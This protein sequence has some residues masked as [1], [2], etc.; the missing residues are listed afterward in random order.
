MLPLQ[1]RHILSK[2]SNQLSFSPM[3]FDSLSQ[4]IGLKNIAGEERKL[5]S[6]FRGSSFWLQK[7]SPS[8]MV[9]FHLWVSTGSD[10]P[11]PAGKRGQVSNLLTWELPLSKASASSKWHVFPL[12]FNLFTSILHLFEYFHL[13]LY[14][15]NPNQITTNRSK[16]PKAQKRLGRLPPSAPPLPAPQEAPQRPLERRPLQQRREATEER[17]LRRRKNG[18]GGWFGLKFLFEK[19]GFPAFQLGFW[20]WVFLFLWVFLGFLWVSWVWV[21]LFLW[22]FLGLIGFLGFGFSCSFGFSWV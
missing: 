22:V 17:D 7:I 13:F 16:P 20:V 19:I 15:Y 14:S 12:F 11:P 1:Y 8:K 18:G 4:T 5:K 21:F 3:F 10:E 2:C 6:F 9:S